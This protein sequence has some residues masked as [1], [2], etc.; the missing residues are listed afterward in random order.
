VDGRG[1][2]RLL[3][4]NGHNPIKLFRAAF[5]GTAALGCELVLDGEIAVP[6]EKGATHIGDLQDE[7]AGRVATASPTSRCRWFTGFNRVG[8]L[9]HYF[10]KNRP[11]GYIRGYTPSL[12]HAPS[13]LLARCFATGN[14]LRTAMRD[15]PPHEAGR[16][17]RSKPWTAIIASV[18]E[19]RRQRSNSFASV[20]SWR[21]VGL[22]TETL[23]ATH[24]QQS[25]QTAVSTELTA[26][27][28]VQ[29]ILTSRVAFSSGAP[30][31]G[32]WQARCAVAEGQL[33]RSNSREKA[34]RTA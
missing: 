14:H 29:R 11:T 3:S 26:M 4:R 5:D 8:A 15:T 18:P 34:S 10:F 27:Y 24:L 33:E 1:V 9:Q 6:D 21:C 23:C 19:P 17:V 32:Q 13:R 16:P 28:A 31:H 20:S 7:I 2:L 22:C 12:A 30:A 25:S